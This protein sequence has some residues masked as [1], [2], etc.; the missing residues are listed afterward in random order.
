MPLDVLWDTSLNGCRTEV[1]EAMAKKP[2]EK[3][4]FGLR[5]D[6]TRSKAAAL[7]S[8]PE[9]ATLAEVKVE[10]GSIQFNVLRQLEK[11]GCVVTSKKEAGDKNRDVTR[12]FLKPL[13]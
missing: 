8:R 7:Y 3:D 4:P 13:T 6:S 9:G 12:Y 5:L 11:R 1:G 10:V 2:T